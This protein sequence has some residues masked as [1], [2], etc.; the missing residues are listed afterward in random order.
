MTQYAAFRRVPIPAQAAQH[1][2]TTII[3][4]PTRGLIDNE[5]LTYMQPGGAIVMDNW[6][7]TMQGA[8][9]RG[10][11]VNWASLP[12]TTPVI[13]A[14]EYASGNVRKMFAANAT[15]LYDVSFSGVGTAVAT[16]R[17]SGNYSVTQLANAGGDWLIA[18]NDA[19][20]FP[21]RYNGTSWLLLNS[22]EIHGPVGT[23]VE[24]GRALVNVCKYKNRLFF[25]EQNSMNAWYLGIDSIAGMMALIPLSG[26]ATKGGKLLFCA[27]WSVD[28]GDGLDDKIVFMTTEG[29]VLIFSGSNPADAA[30]WRQ[31]GRY[32]IPKPIGMNAHVSLGGDLLIA[33]IEGIV[34]LSAAITK[35][36]EQLELAMIT[37]NI[38]KTW[39]AEATAKG[40]I[41]W[42]MARWDEL[43][44][45]FVTWPGGVPGARYCAVVNTGTGAWARL[46]GY[47]ATC[48][49]KQGSNL[50]FGT[51]DGTIMQADRGGYDDGEP[52]VCTI[53]GGWE[54]FQSP[55]ATVIWHQAR[56]AFLAR[57]G[58]TFQP[59]LTATTDY[60]V[61]IP[62][63]P[64]AGVD[65]GTL[66]LWDQGEWDEAKWDA[67]PPPQPTVR[68]T[69]WVSIGQ[70]GFSH[71]PIVQ[72]TMGQTAKPQVE[73]ISIGITY[74]RAGVN[75]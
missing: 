40:S 35:E 12:E 14:F 46:P 71:A 59:Q 16:G 57:P 66:D 48:F 45:M 20:D 47:D 54:I 4:A 68:S 49:I 8:R 36:A 53:V 69:G 41:P 75:V 13:S 21:L 60:I 2:Q 5:N 31:E 19:G 32:Q 34:P 26:A 52:Y 3:P 9:I 1:Y 7:P 6:L 63:P 10:G 64:L 50:F 39:R 38:R 72:I 37:K 29:E 11:C 58:E 42:T 33:T 43:G 17:L 74:E 73:L 55:P 44:I 62:Q 23:P 67:I 24:H 65:P 51:Q 70:T 61:T 22:D 18:V 28:A 56:A 27:S 15:K 25:I 30:N